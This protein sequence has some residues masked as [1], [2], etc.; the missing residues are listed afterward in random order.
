MSEGPGSGDAESAAMRLSTRKLHA[1][2]GFN[3][4]GTLHGDTAFHREA[5]VLSGLPLLTT[6]VRELG[7]WTENDPKIFG[8]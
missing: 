2:E 7:W 8:S 6:W 3:R 5:E 1:Y 4:H